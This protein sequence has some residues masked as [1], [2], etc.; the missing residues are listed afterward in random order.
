MK[1]FKPTSPGLREKTVQDFAELTESKPERSLLIKLKKKSG[2][3]NQGKITVRHRGG[4]SRRFY[5]II[6][7][8]RDKDNIPAQVLSI[9]YDP[10][11]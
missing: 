8:K 5:R 4:G 11:R 10:N 3:N 2:R 9:E 7:F 6:D 1:F